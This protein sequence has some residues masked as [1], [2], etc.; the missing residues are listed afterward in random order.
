MSAKAKWRNEKKHVSGCY[1]LN[2]TLGGNKGYEFLELIYDWA[3]D[4]RILE[5]LQDDQLTKFMQLERANF[6]R[7]RNHVDSLLSDARAGQLRTQLAVKT[8]PEGQWYVPGGTDAGKALERRKAVFWICNGSP[9]DTKLK[10]IKKVRAILKEYI[11]NDDTHGKAGPALG[12]GS[13]WVKKIHKAVYH[14]PPPYRFGYLA[15]NPGYPSSVGGAALLE[16]IFQQ[17]SNMIWPNLGHDKWQDA[18]LFYL[19][20][21][22][23]VQGFSDGNKRVAR[24]AY[25]IVLIKGGHSFIAP[26]ITYENELFNM[27]G[28]A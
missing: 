4:R 2:Y 26:T 17:T 28:A 1:D 24:M 13:E 3:T 7:K 18:A 5:S 6:L 12:R 27:V 25:S 9:D 23:A 19:G 21:I 8:R 16:Y 20:A 14:N 15:G 22:V 11:P 10:E